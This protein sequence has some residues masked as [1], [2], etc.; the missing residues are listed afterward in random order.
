MFTQPLGRVWQNSSLLIKILKK[1]EDEEVDGSQEYRHTNREVSSVK[2]SVFTNRLAFGDR[3]TVGPSQW[4]W[5]ARPAV[6]SSQWGGLRT[7]WGPSRTPHCRR[8][9]S[10][11]RR[12]GGRHRGRPPSRGWCTGSRGSSSAPRQRSPPAGSAAPLPWRR[13]VALLG[14][15]RS[16]RGGRRRRLDFRN[17]FPLWNKEH[18]DLILSW[19]SDRTMI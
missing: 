2:T 4:G 9:C 17:H 1:G 6:D 3:P 12:R 5:L 18:G 15:R 16:C 11:W 7:S 14:P 10:R 19:V 13:W 8:R